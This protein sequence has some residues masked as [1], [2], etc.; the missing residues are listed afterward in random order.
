MEIIAPLLE[1]Y[2]GWGLLIAGLFMLFLYQ[3][4]E[5]KKASNRADEA[6]KRTTQLEDR[7]SE[8]LEDVIKERDTRISSL[9]SANQELNRQH[10]EG[11]THVGDGLNRIADIADLTRKNEEHRD[12]ILSD[13]AS[14]ISA[15][16]TV[17]SKPLQQ[18][19]KDMGE[20]HKADDEIKQEV[21]KIYDMLMLRFPVEQ[22]MIDQIRDM[23]ISTV[24]E[25]ANEKKESTGELPSIDVVLKKTGT[26]S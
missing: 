22:P 10:I 9:E 26:E 1:Q 15:I 14:A 17:G 11:L 2:G 3:R 18:V 12:R 13:A 24:K 16:V 23:V 7:F 4:N 20:L 5:A 21:S 6:D 8:R 19:V 25:V